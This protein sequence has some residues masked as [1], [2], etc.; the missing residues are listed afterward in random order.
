MYQS[1][2][3]YFLFIFCCVF[4]F[5]EN[6][7]AQNESY[8]VGQEVCYDDNGT[9]K[10]G[11]YQGANV[12]YN[13][14][15]WPHKIQTEGGNGSVFGYDGLVDP[16]CDK[17]G[18]S[19]SNTGNSSDTGSSSDTGTSNTNTASNT[20]IQPPAGTINLAKD[21]NASVRNVWGNN[22]ASRAVDGITPDNCGSNCEEGSILAESGPDKKNW[23]SID[24]GAVY[25]LE[26]I[27]VWNRNG[28]CKWTFKD[29][30]VLVSE[31]KMDAPSETHSF[32]TNKHHFIGHN[33]NDK[34]VHY[35]PNKA[36]GRYVMV[37]TDNDHIAVTEVQVYGKNQAVTP[38]TAPEHPCKCDLSSTSSV[39]GGT[40]VPADRSKYNTHGLAHTDRP[41][42]IGTYSNNKLTFAWQDFSSSKGVN[43]SQY[44]KQGNS[45]KK[46]WRKDAPGSLDLLG[47][48]TSD[49]TNF[50][51]FTTKDENMAFTKGWVKRPHILHLVKLKN[52]GDLDWCRDLN[53]DKTY[54]DTPVYSPMHAGTAGITYGGNKV[55]IIMSSNS[56]DVDGTQRHQCGFRLS[57]D[58]DGGVA[59]KTMWYSW[60]HSFDQ[61]ILF[62]GTDFVLMDMPDSDGAPNFMPGPGIELMKILNSSNSHKDGAIGW[63]AYA[64]NGNWNA[65]FLNMGDIRLGAEGYAI[66]FASQ[67]DGA[68]YE[69]K[70]PRNLG[71]VHVI[72]N[73]TD[74]TKNS[75]TWK[76]AN[77]LLVK[78][79]IVNT[80]SKNS[81][82]TGDSRFDSRYADKGDVQNTGIVWLT[83]YNTNDKKH[84]ASRPKLVSLGNAKFLA[85]WEEWGINV[86]GGGK[87]NSSTYEKTK[88]M[89]VDEYG[90][91]TLDVNGDGQKNL[92]DAKDMGDIRLRLRDEFFNIDGK[93]A[94]IEFDKGAN[95]FKLYQI[96]QNLQ[97]GTSMLDF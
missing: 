75:G 68:L 54:N 49:G 32:I 59:A 94:W 14:H 22:P 61:R 44:T 56:T 97:M 15:T 43:I 66:L 25:E 9:W 67:K 87:V 2:I 7:W 77:D 73:F 29:F 80:K 96:D 76:P 41:K 84:T 95:K 78:N 33:E 46:E 55:G 8:N 85:I 82:A 62:D 5:A 12:N 50:Y 30:W 88:A 64:R 3:K 65:T 38:S 10:K 71:L 53:K 18:G 4:W 51:C 20:D 1:F 89:V 72:K 60:K 92:Q 42:L 93:A 31:Y 70:Q 19:S 74:K 24:L 81:A 69:D 35:N 16:C 13:N 63:Y 6:I 21:K 47:G 91:V 48:F 83:E 40:P 23:V 26:K 58:S 17:C 52:N 36:K 57:V 86:D 11:V 90:N 37:Y 45:F 34:Y 39:S 79:D 27:V 28:C